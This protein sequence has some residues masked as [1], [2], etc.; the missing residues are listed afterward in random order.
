MNPLFVGI[1]V[2][3]EKNTVQILD[4]HGSSL[5]RFKVPNDLPG[6]E[7]LVERILATAS[8]VG[9]D[10]VRIGMEAT[11]LYWWHLFQ[12]LYE[13]PNLATLQPQIAVLNPKVIDGFKRVYTDIAKTDVLDARVIA[14][15]VAVWPGALFPAPGPQNRRAAAAD[16]LPLPP[17]PVLD[18]GEEPGPEPSLPPVL[19]LRQ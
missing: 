11:N 9:A 5:T 2:G 12:A 15:L 6:K 17:G 1:D 4:V 10:G 16:P 14:D 3:L 18:P 7:E 19:Q 13:D 8:Q